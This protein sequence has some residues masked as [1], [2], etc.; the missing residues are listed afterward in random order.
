MERAKAK[1]GRETAPVLIPLVSCWSNLDSP[2]PPPRTHPLAAAA[3]AAA[4]ARPAMGGG[5]N[6]LFGELSKGLAVTSGLKKVTSPVRVKCVLS[7]R[8]AL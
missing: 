1:Q 4:P 2:P 7:C 8:L 6:A 3:R 5:S